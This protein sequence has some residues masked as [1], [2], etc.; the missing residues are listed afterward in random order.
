MDAQNIMLKLF[1]MG[2]RNATKYTEASKTFHYPLHIRLYHNYGCIEL[3][4]IFIAGD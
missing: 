3:C 2:N 4:T 1:F